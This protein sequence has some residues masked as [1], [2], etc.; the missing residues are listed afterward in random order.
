MSQM[1]YVQ[2]LETAHNPPF[3]PTI[4]RVGGKK[5]SGSRNNQPATGPSVGLSP[6]LWGELCV[7]FLL[8]EID[9]QVYFPKYKTFVLTTKLTVKRS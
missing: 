9:K 8:L 5:S 3:K 2:R 4:G 6:F 7:V 1:Y